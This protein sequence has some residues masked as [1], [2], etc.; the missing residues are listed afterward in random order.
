[1]SRM[2][3]E[4]HSAFPMTLE[5]RMRNQRTVDSDV[6]ERLPIKNYFFSA[7]VTGC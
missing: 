2:K 5:V 1:M 3:P 4:S 6:A 7:S